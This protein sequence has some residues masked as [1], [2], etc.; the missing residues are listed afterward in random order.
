MTTFYRTFLFPGPQPQT[1]SPVPNLSLP[2]LVLSLYLPAP[3]LN[4][5]LSAFAPRFN[6]RS[7]LS[8]I[9]NE[10][11]IGG[12]QYISREFFFQKN[13]FYRDMSNELFFQEIVYLML[14]Y[15]MLN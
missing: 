2:I 14:R 8:R 10:E 3:A 6:Y 13:Y 11:F 5:Y 12:I 1:C 4:F 9:G 7:W 15:G